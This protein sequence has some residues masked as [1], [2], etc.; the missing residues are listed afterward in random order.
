M[1]TP[2]NLLELSLTKFSQQLMV[3]VPEEFLIEF[4]YSD[5]ENYRDVVST[6]T[7]YWI[8]PTTWAVSTG[9][10]GKEAKFIVDVAGATVYTVDRIPEASRQIVSVVYTYEEGA[11]SSVHRTSFVSSSAGSVDLFTSEPQLVLNFE[12]AVRMFEGSIVWE[13]NR[14]MRCEFVPSD[15]GTHYTGRWN[16]G[17][18]TRHSR[19]CF[20]FDA[21]VP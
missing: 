4:S 11:L 13:N 19:R 1:F 2:V 20:H 16:D 8:S 3:E 12:W 21:V 18:L 6:T 7:T 17:S 14:G 15:D 9:L 10:V 5:P